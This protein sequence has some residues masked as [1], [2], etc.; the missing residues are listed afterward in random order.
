MAAAAP[1]SLGARPDAGIEAFEPPPGP[2]SEEWRPIPGY[3]GYEASNHGNIRSLLWRGTH[4]LKTPRI[5]RGTTNSTGHRHVVLR[6]RV[7]VGVHR[8]VA[9]TFHGSPPPGATVCRHLDGDP[10]NNRPENLCRG[11]PKENSDDM[12]RHG[13]R[14]FGES[15]HWAKLTEQQVLNIYA[16]RARGS[17]KALADEMDIKECTVYSIWS[18]RNWGWLTGA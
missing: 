12:L 17:A 16:R 3:D 10:T 6:G 7:A 1:S 5:M 18:G 11:T 9:L 15:N 13:T 2:D 8:L 4:P 14:K